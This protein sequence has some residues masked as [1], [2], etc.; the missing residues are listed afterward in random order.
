M[1]NTQNTQSNKNIKEEQKMENKA[2]KARFLAN[3]DLSIEVICDGEKIS[4]KIPH[5]RFVGPNAREFYRTGYFGDKWTYVNCFTGKEK[6]V[7]VKNYT[8]IDY[9]MRVHLYELLPNNKVMAIF[10]DF[11]STRAT[12]TIRPVVDRIYVFGNNHVIHYRGLRDLSLGN[13]S[14]G[15]VEDVRFVKDLKNNYLSSYGIYPST[16]RPEIMNAIYRH[17]NQESSTAYRGED[18]PY[19]LERNYINYIRSRGGVM[20]TN[21]PTVETMYADLLTRPIVLPTEE[22]I[23][24]AKNENLIAAIGERIGDTIMITCKLSTYYNTIHRI[25]LNKKH[26]STFSKNG[27]AEVGGARRWTNDDWHY[28]SS[29]SQYDLK[30][31]S[32]INLTLDMVK[33]LPYEK[34]VRAKHFAKVCKEHLSLFRLMRKFAYH[35]G[36]DAYSNSDKMAIQHLI[37]CCD[38]DECV[39]LLTKANGFPAFKMFGAYGRSITISDPLHELIGKADPMATSLNAAIGLNH[40]Q[41]KMAVELD[42]TYRQYE[43]PTAYYKGASYYSA[44]RSVI[45]SYR[46]F[47]H[48]NT[49]ADLRSTS[50]ADFK[51]WI[52]WAKDRASQG[53]NGNLNFGWGWDRVLPANLDRMA[54]VRFWAK[55]NYGS[56]DIQSLLDLVNMNYRMTQVMPTTEDFRIRDVEDLRRR[57][58][59]AVI[60]QRMF[61]NKSQ[62]EK[63]EITKPKWDKFTFKNDEYEIIPPEKPE[64]IVTEGRVLSHCVGGYVDRVARGETIILFLR[65]KNDPTKPF[66]TLNIDPEGKRLIQAHGYGNRWPATDPEI[67]PFLDEWVKKFGFEGW[68]Y[69]RTV[70]RDHY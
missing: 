63:W 52:D 7:E 64:E 34:A 42:K 54:L 1:N 18:N 39:A 19:F 15:Y 43:S 70:N 69:I 30:K 35:L 6:P 23:T 4:V 33:G 59:R 31:V 25:I 47:V 16:Q 9:D 21:N 14:N 56:S 8:T 46:Y 20:A 28:E 53:D 13:L 29:P 60:A 50:N 44:V 12:G 61:D 24:T 65:K 26:C 58:D 45:S 3:R 49:N 40:E 62:L 41:L 22:Q 2:I 68:D 5:N 10:L 55:H 38:S 48:G 11:E 51:T 27:G 17:L 57:H 36:Q 67:L 37:W 32:I 66:Y